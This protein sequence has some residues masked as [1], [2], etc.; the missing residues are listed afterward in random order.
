MKRGARLV[1]TLQPGQRVF[2]AGLAGESA[3]LRDELQADPGRARGVTFCT[4]QYPG[5][6]RTDYLGLHPEAR[7]EAHFMSPALRA[8]RAS[9]RAALMALDYRG[10]ARH[11]LEGPAPDVAIAQ[12]TPPDADG[13]CSAGL[14]T[15]GTFRRPSAAAQACRAALIGPC[16]MRSIV[17]AA[18][19][20]SS[21]SARSRSRN[22][23]WIMRPATGSTISRR[24]WFISTAVASASGSRA[25]LSTLSQMAL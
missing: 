5:I 10:I 7:L 17:P 2:V 18:G 16:S 15:S 20:A 3:L 21:R 6:D 12:L 1:D 11:C 23:V 9:G 22:S 24:N 4:A 13:W 25:P 14:S 19:A 8:A